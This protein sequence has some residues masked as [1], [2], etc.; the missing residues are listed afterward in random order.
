MPV[1]KTG[2]GYVTSTTVFII[3]FSDK[4]LK[5]VRGTYRVVRS[6]LYLRSEITAYSEG[7]VVHIHA[8]P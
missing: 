2:K 1:P 5:R 7:G 4:L 3:Y 6:T 8:W